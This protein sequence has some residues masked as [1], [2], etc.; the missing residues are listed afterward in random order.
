MRIS[1]CGMRNEKR[2]PY[3]KGLFLL[4]VYLI[5]AT[6]CPAAHAEIKVIEAD[7]TYDMGENDS[8]ADARRIAVQEAKRK[9]FELAG[10]FVESLTQV[11]DFQLSKDE[12]KAYTAG[13]LETEVIS[14]QMHGTTD[15][16][17]IDVKVR[18]RIDTDVLLQQ[19]GHYRGS[20]DLKEQ[21]LSSAGENEALQKERDALV[22]QLA[23]EKDKARAETTRKRLAGVLAREEAYDDT[24]RVWASLAIS[25][26]D[27][28][29]NGHE[30][31]QA[32]LD[33]SA[34]VLQRVVTADPRN[35]R[36]RYLL[37]AVY[38]RQ[39]NHNAAENELRAAIHHNPSNPAPHLKL[40]LLLRERG[41]Y[42]EALREFHF[43][44]RL[45]PHNILPVY[46]SGMTFKDMGKCGKT[47]QYLNRFM[48][49]KGAVKYPQ[50]REQALS[51]IDECGGERPGRHKRVRQ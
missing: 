19:I 7:G 18:C 41:K 3:R 32:D 26:E 33:S 50:K 43:V 2:S 23:S 9:A 17:K 14:E 47:V 36:A 27:T 11:K 13:V 46:Y 42:Q 37:A 39:G 24:N 4:A 5:A 15:R 44:E 51:T 8:R 34:V 48:K 29:G 6:W 20:E 35:Q 40:G 21:L 30:I 38:Q 12:V 31:R 22:K 1:E 16:P 45:R 25:I 10:A 28:D 49:D